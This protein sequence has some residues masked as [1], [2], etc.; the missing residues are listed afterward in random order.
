MHATSDAICTLALVRHAHWRFAPGRRARSAGRSS[1]SVLV[2]SL[3]CPLCRKLADD[4]TV[5]ACQKQ[6]QPAPAVSQCALLADCSS[7]LFE[8]CDAQQLCPFWR[9]PLC[10]AAVCVFIASRF[11]VAA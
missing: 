4:D 6:T 10:A 5:H 3:R 1:A 11:V 2:H 9:L 7:G 8:H